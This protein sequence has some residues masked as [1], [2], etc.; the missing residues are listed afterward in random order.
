MAADRGLDFAEVCGCT[1]RRRVSPVGDRVDGY[2]LK[3]FVCRP[4]EQSA[5]GVYV[6]VDAAIGAETE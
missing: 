3:T 4:F 6:A 2:V 5:N 1:L